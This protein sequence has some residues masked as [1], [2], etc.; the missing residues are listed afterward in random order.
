MAESSPCGIGGYT[1]FE[2]IAS[3]VVI[4]ILSGV[5]ILAFQSDSYKVQV[6]VERF[7][8]NTRYLQ[9]KAISEGTRCCIT[10]LS[11][12]YSATCNG[13]SVNFPDGTSVVTVHGSISAY[14]GSNAIKNLCFDYSGLPDCNRLTRIQVGSKKVLIYP[15]T[16]G[17][18]EEK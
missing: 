9:E 3:L 7:I 8:V 18:F 10:F 5:A 11:K 1:L 4:A 15:Q 13:N 17:V 16:G 14:C 2:L 6:D 12:G